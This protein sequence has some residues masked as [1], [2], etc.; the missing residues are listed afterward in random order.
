MT[1]SPL[2]L[3]RKH[4]VLLATLLLAGCHTL[5][6]QPQPPLGQTISTALATQGSPVTYTSQSDF[7]TTSARLKSAIEQ[8][9]LTLFTTVDHA[10]GAAKVGQT[11]APNTLYIFG[12]PTAGTPLMLAN[13]AL[14][15]DLPLKAQVREQ[16]GQVLITVSD[17]RAITAAAGVTEPAQVIENIAGALDAIATEAA[18]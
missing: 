11:L 13:P 16:D 9:G 8:R 17:I 7:A 2:S 4:G 3:P 10:A 18:G 6:P 1:H 14:G 12:N 15:I 5:S